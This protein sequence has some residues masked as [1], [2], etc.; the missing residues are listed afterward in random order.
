VIPG[1]P[2]SEAYVQGT[3]TYTTALY[4][5]LPPKE[6]AYRWVAKEAIQRHQTPIKKGIPLIP[7]EVMQLTVGKKDYVLRIRFKMWKNRIQGLK[8]YRYALLCARDK[9]VVKSL[10]DVGPYNGWEQKMNSFGKTTGPGGAKSEKTPVNTGAGKTSKGKNKQKEKDYRL[11]GTIGVDRGI[12]I[13]RG[14][15]CRYYIASCSTLR[16]PMAPLNV[17][18][19]VAAEKKNRMIEESGG[20]SGCK[21]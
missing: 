8:W 13:L 3:N 21:R 14:S 9:D 5:C 2:W 19:V 1:A 7:S 4:N 17:V 10:R 18:H 15:D 11:K 6:V 20:G 12:E 16:P